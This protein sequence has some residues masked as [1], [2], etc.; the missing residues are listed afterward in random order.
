M[1]FG[2]IADIVTYTRQKTGQLI[3]GAGNAGVSAASKI[4]QGL[5]NVIM[6]F[7][8]SA[9]GFNAMLDVQPDSVVTTIR[10]LYAWVPFACFAISTI[11]FVFFFDLD[12]KM[13]KTETIVN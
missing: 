5:A 11:I 1:L 2:L 12:K 4:G 3:A 13:G 9:A 8:L 6:G 7:S 10:V